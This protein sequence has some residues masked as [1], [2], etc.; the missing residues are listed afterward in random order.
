MLRKSPCSRPKGLLTLRHANEPGDGFSWDSRRL[1]QR[2]W[3]CLLSLASEASFAEM[4][5]CIVD[6]DKSLPCWEETTQRIDKGMLLARDP[7]LFYAEVPLYVSE[8]DDNGVSQIT[9][10]VTLSLCISA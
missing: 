10:K 1:C 5:W 8:L 9:V 4:T 7:I 3:S 6:V 2:S